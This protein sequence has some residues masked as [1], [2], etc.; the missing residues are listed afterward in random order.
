MNVATPAAGG[1]GVLIDDFDGKTLSEDGARRLVGLIHEHR[2]VVLR[3]QRLSPTEHLDM[4]RRLGTPQ[5]YF[6]KNYHHPDHPEIFVSS[7]VPENG[8]KIGVAGTGRYWHTDCQFFDQPLPITTVTPRVVPQ[9]GERGT[10]FIDTE[11]VL[12]ALPEHLRSCVEGRRARHEAKWRYKVQASDIDKSIT[13]I[14]AEF[15]AITPTVTHPCVLI[16]PKT[17]RRHLYVSEGFT[18][19]LEGYS[20][21]EGRE[22][23]HEIFEFMERPEFVH[24]H[25]W[26]EGDVLM[27]DNRAVL[28][29]ASDTLP[30]EHSV[31]HRI[32]FYDG[33][34]FYENA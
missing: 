12:N 16:H 10:S 13:E 14:L 3:G 23:L 30:G 2:L 1:L 22:I 26:A 18:V 11:R 27:W 28:H 31:S 15:S 17:G 19:G 29:R 9:R 33:L 6:Q 34:P 7:N 32:G 5:I 4:V 20:T 21:E 8:K 25:R 24:A